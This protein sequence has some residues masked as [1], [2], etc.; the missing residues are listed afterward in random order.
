MAYAFEIRR[1]NV[2]LFSGETHFVCE[3][4]RLGLPSEYRHWPGLLKTSI[5]DG[6]PFGR[7]RG[8]S[9]GV[10]HVDVLYMQQSTGITLLVRS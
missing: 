9:A 3:G 1:E 4:K 8:S 6:K 2:E 10:Q 5:G 7:A